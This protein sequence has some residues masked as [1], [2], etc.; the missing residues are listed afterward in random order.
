MEKSLKSYAKYLCCSLYRQ[1]GNKLD[2][3]I[4]GFQKCGTTS[5]F[6]YLDMHPL[7]LGTVEKEP[8]LFT[9][10]Y[11]PD[12]N[13]WDMLS[14]F[15]SRRLLVRNRKAL[16]FEATPDYA[17]QEHVAERLYRHNPKAKLIM[18]VREP[19][20][21]AISEYNMVCEI[22]KKG[23]SPREDVECAYYEYLQ[24]PEQ[25]PF[26]WFV[27][28]EFS[29]IEQAGSFLSSAFYYPDFIRQGIY[30]VH[31]KR[32]YTFFAPEQILVLEDRELRE[33][34]KETLYEI[35][36]F[37]N[38]PHIDWKD[39]DLVNSN[40]GVYTQQ[41][42]AECKHALKKIF[43]PWNEKFFELIGRRMNW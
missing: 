5:L 39:E 1:H 16:L 32:F 31:L 29:Q 19:V 15:R 8:L 42:P 17:F 12:F 4:V 20:S 7:C 3:F 41:V 18:L 11:K 14:F 23:E 27:E 36:T 6:H 37:L 28:K 24:D 13:K 38:I 22:V 33:H 26:S 2:F 25:Y 21:R 34:K 43:D 9:S 10:K 30:Y 40:I 35:E